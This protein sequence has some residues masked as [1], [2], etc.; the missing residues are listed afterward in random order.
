[1]LEQ[2]KDVLTIKDLKEIL[3]I[4]TNNIYKLINTNTIKHI[5]VGNRI[6]IPK[7][8]LINYLTK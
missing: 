4:G 7:V 6:L 5:R 8:N 2:Y 1:M 3:P